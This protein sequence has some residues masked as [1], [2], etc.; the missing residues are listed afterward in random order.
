MAS[1]FVFVL[2]LNFMCQAV[3][4]A[5]ALPIPQ[6][7][8]LPHWEAPRV[9]LEI[10]FQSLFTTALLFS[11]LGAYM[12]TVFCRTRTPVLVFMRR[13]PRGATL[14]QTINRLPS[15]LRAL[16]SRGYQRRIPTRRGRISAPMATAPRLWAPRPTRHVHLPLP[17]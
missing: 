13:L 1:L 12:M 6:R 4:V 7:A 11:I 3:D 14:Q 8:S 5:E 15:M 17:S 10:R 16:G 2:F 9:A